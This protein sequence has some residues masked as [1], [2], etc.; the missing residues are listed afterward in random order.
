MLVRTQAAIGDLGVGFASFAEA[1][2]LPFDSVKLD[3]SLMT[4]IT[5][6]GNAAAVVEASRRDRDSPR[7][8]ADGA[9]HRAARTAGAGSRMGCPLAQGYVFTK[10]LAPDDFEEFIRRWDPAS[11][12]VSP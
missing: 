7:P 10:P 9:G 6:D 1:N 4:R 3:R 11:V 8:R 5:T 2:H 12:A